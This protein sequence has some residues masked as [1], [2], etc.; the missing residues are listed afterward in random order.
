MA[1]PKT[2]A[3]PLGD[4]PTEHAFEPCFYRTRPVKARAKL[5]GLALACPGPRAGI[6]G[7]HD[8]IEI[9]GIAQGNQGF[10]VKAVQQA[11]LLRNNFVKAEDGH[12]G[13]LSLYM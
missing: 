3:L 1:V 8:H 6:W 10:L 12:H 7:I 9:S 11:L 13:G 5:S 2:A 4:A